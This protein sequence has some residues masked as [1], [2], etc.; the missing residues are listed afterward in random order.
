MSTIPTTPKHIC[1]RLTSKASRCPILELTVQHS[2][3][4]TFVAH[5][6]RVQVTCSHH[7]KQETSKMWVM[8]HLSY[9]VPHNLQASTHEQLNCLVMF[10][11]TNNAS[12]G[13]KLGVDFSRKM[14]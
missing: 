11:G 2:H 1:H 6:Q 13:G 14:R 12:Y 10:N 8:S 4:L 9:S 7:T 3:L 5:Q